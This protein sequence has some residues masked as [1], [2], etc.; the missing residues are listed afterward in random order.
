MVSQKVKQMKNKR[1]IIKPREKKYIKKDTWPK[2]I[3]QF[4]TEKY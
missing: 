1:G 3:T 4:I 2:Y